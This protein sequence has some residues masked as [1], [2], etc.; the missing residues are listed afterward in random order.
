MADI[1]QYIL[2]TFFTKT[3]ISLCIS[4][5]GRLMGRSGWQ[6]IGSRFLDHMILEGIGIRIRIMMNIYCGTDYPAI[7]L[8]NSFYLIE[9]RTEAQG[10]FSGD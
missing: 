3:D 1:I 6:G 8:S 5:V 10:G 2:E 4:L 7:L 9:K